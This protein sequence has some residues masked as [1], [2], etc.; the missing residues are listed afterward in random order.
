M[1]NVEFQ[2]LSRNCSRAVV[3]SCFSKRL[4]YAMTIDSDP[5]VDDALDIAS[6]IGCSELFCM[7]HPFLMTDP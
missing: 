1:T 2:E 7:V 5:D 6:V 4:M 3:A